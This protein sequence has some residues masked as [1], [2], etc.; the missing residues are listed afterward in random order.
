MAHKKLIA[1]YCVYNEAEYLEYSLK[2]I[3]D[4][5][6]K[7]VIVEGAFAETFEANDCAKTSTDGTLNILKNFPDPECK[8]NRL[9]A[10]PQPQLQQRGKVFEY[11]HDDCWLWLI[12]GDEVYTE[13]NIK[14]IKDATTKKDVGYESIRINSYVFIND[15]YHYVDI[16]MPRLFKIKREWQYKFVEPNKL[17]KFNKQLRQMSALPEIELPDIFFHHYSYCKSPERFM[18][19]RQERIRQTG[20]FKWD[21]DDAGQIVSPG[22]DIKLFGEKH[23]EVMKGHPRYE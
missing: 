11:I 4:H 7:I 9:F 6:D 12:D 15:F 3:Y 13:E 23:P 17:V 18:L 8:I 5:V 2:S 19:K 14:K 10:L 20:S 21:L 16:K 1:F 22:V